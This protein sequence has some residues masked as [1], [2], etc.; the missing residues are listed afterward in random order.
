MSV[1]LLISIIAVSGCTQNKSIDHVVKD[2]M[3]PIDMANIKVGGEIGRRIDITVK[4]NLLLLDVDRDFLLPFQKKDGKD[5][6][7]KA[8]GKLIDAAVKMAY[9]TRDTTVIALK[10][11]LISEII[12]TQGTD[13]YIGNMIPE[14]RMWK[15]WDLHEMNYIIYG[16]ISDYK[17]FG[18]KQSLVAAQKAADYIIKNWSTMPLDWEKKTEIAAFVSVTGLDR[19]MITLYGVTGDKRYLEFEINQR[20]LA[21]WDPGIVIG[22]RPLVEGHTYAYLASCL[23]QLELYRVQ[24]DEIL[25]VP[26]MKAMNFMTG[27]DGMGIT[28]GVGQAEIWTDDQDGGRDLQETCS[29]CYQIRVYENLLRLKGDSRYGDIM[30]RTIFNTLFGAQSPDGRRLRYFTPFEG[31]REYCGE[32]CCTGNFRR[33]ISELP[34]MVYYRSGNGVAINLYSSSAANIAMENGVFVV[35]KQETDYPNSGHVVIRVDPSKPTSFPLKLR[36]PS[37]CRNASISVNGKPSE[38]TFVPGT[39]AVIER[40]WKAGD[41]VVLDMPMEW[42][43]V[44]GRQRQAGR[45]AVLRGPLVFCLNPGQNES[46]ALKEASDIGRIVIDLASIE[47]TAVADSTVRPGGIGCRLKAGTIVGALGNAKNIT[48]TLS[49]FADPNGRCIYFKVPELSTAVA[50]ELTRP[51]E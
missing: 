5:G 19:T 3:V 44:K 29:V 48:I 46:L 11:H 35:I 40:S 27:K 50:D 38:R 12:E 7:Y 45:V 13:G 41:Q 43:L 17:L 8:L 9:Y 39:F 21:N 2:Q 33:I 23:A 22:R 25:L 16:L 36:I 14:N 51:W 37:W 1:F 42:R 49:E 15:V 6:N 10:N 26:T 28:G 24:K 31:S 30:E 18:D 47:Q 34:S 32:C 20:N 4:N